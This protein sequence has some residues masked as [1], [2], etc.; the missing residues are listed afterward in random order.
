M[1]EKN[2]IE[3]WSPLFLRSELEG[4]QQPYQLPFDYLREL[5]RQAEELKL[6]PLKWMP[7]DYDDTLARPATPATA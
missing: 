7:W 2:F 6:N 4:G 3:G 5:L 1:R